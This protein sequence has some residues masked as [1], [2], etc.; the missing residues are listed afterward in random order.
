MIASPSA[1]AVAAYGGGDD[2]G[3]HG[4]QGDGADRAQPV[5]AERGGALAPGSGHRAEERRR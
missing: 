2:R 3:A 1:R 4:A 5:D